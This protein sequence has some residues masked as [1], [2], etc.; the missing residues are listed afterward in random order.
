MAGQVLRDINMLCVSPEGR[1]FVYSSYSL[2]GGSCTRPNSLRGGSC[3]RP[4]MTGRSICGR[5]LL[6]HDVLHAGSSLFSTCWK[7][8]VLY[9]YI[10]EYPTFV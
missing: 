8:T 10:E 9:I 6:A 3:T 2:R 4:I 5:Y 7:F 1:R